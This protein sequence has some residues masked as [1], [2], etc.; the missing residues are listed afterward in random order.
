EVALP[1]RAVQVDVDQVEPGRRPEVPEQAHLHVFGLQ[2][3]AEQRVVEQGDLA[4]RDVVRGPPVGVERLDLLRRRGR[5]DG[6]LRRALHGREPNRSQGP[7]RPG[8]ARAGPALNL[9]QARTAGS[10][11]AAAFADW[12]RTINTGRSV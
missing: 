8:C 3:L 5:L 1:D 9:R 6:A 4:D 7:G 12:P 2:R 10:P 11:V